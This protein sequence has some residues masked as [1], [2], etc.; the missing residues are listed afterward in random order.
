MARNQL[1]ACVISALACA[2]AAGAGAQAEGLPL[3]VCADPNNMPFSRADGAG[4]EN[5]LAKLV[6][7]RLGRPVAFVWR[8]QRRG[9]LREGL[10]AG[11]CDLVAGV[12]AKTTMAR[13]TRPYYR[14]T[15][16]FVTRPRDKAVARLDD[17][18]LKTRR[19]GVQL[20]GDDGMNTP[21]AH[22]LAWRGLVANVRG[23]S[24]YGDYA[25]PDPPAAIVDAVARGDID[26]AAVWGP[27][28]GYVAARES[29][30]LV[31]TPIDPS[32]ARLPLR[33]SVSM[34]V[35]KDEPQLAEAVQRVL[36]ASKPQIDRMLAEYHVP[37]VGNEQQVVGKQ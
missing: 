24:V 23:F 4:F 12:P 27:L 5:R 20:I 32:G 18:S 3:R 22:E 15:Y 19:I 11:K 2:V 6:G 7:A 28:A 9:F 35:R 25:K 37:Q 1:L 21:P 31:V 34:A 36:D 14:S 10:N 16:V 8:A 33:F 29:P 13:V 30:P 17:P 26:V